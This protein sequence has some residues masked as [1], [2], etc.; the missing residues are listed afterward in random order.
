MKMTHYRLSSS[1]AF[2]QGVSRFECYIRRQSRGMTKAVTGHR[3]PK[4]GTLQSK[5]RVQLFGLVCR[6]CYTPDRTPS[7]KTLAGFMPKNF[8]GSRSLPKLK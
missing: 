7:L 5:V 1:G 4:R 2:S 3:T 6:Q 8:F